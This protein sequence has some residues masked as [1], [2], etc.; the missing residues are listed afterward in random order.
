MTAIVNLSLRTSTFPE[1]MK[2]ATIKC[3]HKKDSTEEPS[4]YR[5]LS[6]LP[7][8]SKI[9]ERAAVDQIIQFIEANNLIS[10]NQHAYRKGHSTITSLAEVTNYIYKEIDKGL[11]VGMASIDLSKAFDS[12][13]H[14]QL[15]QKLT[16]IGMGTM[17]VKWIES[18]LSNRTQ[19]TKFTSMT[20]EMEK[21]TSGVPQGSILGPVLFIIFSNDLITAFNEQTHV[22]SYADDTQLIETG[23]TI[24]EVKAKLERTIKT[25][26]D[27]YT[28]NSLM[29]NPA[30]T[31][32]II[33]RT[34]RGKENNI[35]IK[36][37]EEGKE[38]EIIP[39][40][41]IKIL[42]V[43]IDENLRFDKQVKHVR[44]KA[45]AATKNLYRIQ[46]LLP[47]KYKKVLYNSLV[48]SHFN[49]ADVIWGGCSKQNKEQLQTT[50]NFAMRTILGTDR[51]SPSNEALQK[52]NYLNLENKRQ[53]HEAVFAYK[54][55]N[56]SHPKEIC[57]IYTEQKSKCNT[58]S[59]AKLILN[60]PK[61]KTTLYEKSPLYRTIQTWNQLPHH[62]KI[63][64]PATFKT[65]TQK[66][67]IQSCY[68]DSPQGRG[69]TE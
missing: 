9:F 63:T 62:V 53:V 34:N 2:E 37:T 61:H 5:P 14:S 3:L 64:P 68:G 48:A 12:I 55:I 24:E 11:I 59:A 41:C 56:G 49:Y 26:Q 38:V 20:S 17:T 66:Y 47:I 33:F 39:E 29:C 30:K 45:T 31:E 57:N 21:V 23:K 7:I 44:G 1:S 25:A 65:I 28:N 69:V 15:L 36:V 58:R 52:L 18:Y 32:I 60:N 10:R 22:V 13:I 50:Q 27:W 42:G 46:D 43:H 51:R 35:K 4:N 40:E 6:I 67:K 54:A 16:N 19:K 8:L